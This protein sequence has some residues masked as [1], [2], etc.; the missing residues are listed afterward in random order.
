MQKHDGQFEVAIHPLRHA[1]EVEAC[2]KFMAGSEPWITLRR[3]HQDAI[4]LVQDSVKEVYVALV[5]GS[6]VGFIILDMRGPFAGYVQTIGVMPEWR[7]R[8]IGKKLIAFAEARIFRESPN[9]FLCVSSFNTRAQKLYAQLG[10]ERIGELKNY[11]ISGHAEILMRKTT[12]P[13]N[14]L[15]P[16]R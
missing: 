15:R 6:V 13:R 9:V 1:D 10:Y 11:V 7:N 4:N 12:G 16:L 3:T 5:N 2:A 8:G 14:G